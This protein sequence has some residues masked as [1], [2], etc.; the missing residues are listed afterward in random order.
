MLIALGM[1]ICLILGIV[2]WFKLAFAGHV[3][4]RTLIYMLF[5]SV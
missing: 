5:S 3:L 2:F 1:W 4:L